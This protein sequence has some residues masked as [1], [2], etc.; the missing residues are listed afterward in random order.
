[1]RAIGL[2]RLSSHG[3]MLIDFVASD[4]KPWPRDGKAAKTGMIRPWETM[5]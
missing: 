1:L 4:G 5:P 2:R 3:Q